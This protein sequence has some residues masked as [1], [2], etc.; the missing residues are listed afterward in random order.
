M[1]RASINE[2]LTLYDSSMNEGERQTIRFAQKYHIVTWFLNI[3]VV[4]YIIYVIVN[5]FESVFMG[6]V[7]FSI[8]ALIASILYGTRYKSWYGH[9][10]LIYFI[11][12]IFV[13]VNIM[14]FAAAWIAEFVP[15]DQYGGAKR[16]HSTW[17]QTA[18]TLL[19]FFQAV[20]HALSIILL[21]AVRRR[22]ENRV[23]TDRGGKKQPHGKQVLE[24]K[25]QRDDV[26]RQLRGSKNVK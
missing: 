13:I 24:Y 5:D 17:W 19:F 4:G 21:V 15:G 1:H 14:I 10:I 6:Y 11:L 22:T 25:P 8:F 23:L 18:L 16:K 9:N 12:F 3:L 20:L 26:E 7:I 2:G